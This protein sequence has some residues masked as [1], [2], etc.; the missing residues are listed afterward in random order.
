MHH[1]LLELAHWAGNHPER[2]VLGG[3]GSIAAKRPEGGLVM[4]RSQ[5]W[6][7]RLDESAL[8]VL[9]A[10]QTRALIREV[11]ELPPASPAELDA[12][13][14]PSDWVPSPQ[15]WLL[16]D[17]FATFEDVCFA[18]H[19]Q[20]VAVNQI[21]CSPRA[22]QFSDRRNLPFEVVTCGSASVLIPFVMPGP[23]L[24]KE[25]RRKLVLWRDRYKETPK[26]ILF[27]NH[28]M[29]ALGSSAE[30]VRRVT[31]MAVKSAEVFVGAAM[32]GGPEFLKPNFVAQIDATKWC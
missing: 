24:A 17:L 29:M 25:V 2:W 15:A 31:A 22:R 28:G 16:A 27:Q 20:P 13:P 6:L 11:D 21:L 8:A 7:S 3:E 19:T 23:G 18:L 32:M 12:P 10:D 5:T 30:E 26:L 4:N 14:P 1:E 9:D